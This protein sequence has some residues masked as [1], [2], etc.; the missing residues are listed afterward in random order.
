M[1]YFLM[2]KNHGTLS[3]I[4]GEW[5]V[6][7]L[8]SIKVFHQVVAVGSFTKAALQ[9]D[10]SVAMTSKHM[11][12]LERLLGTK[13]LHR[14]SRNIHLTEAGEQYYN[15]SLYALEILSCAEQTAKGATSIAQ[16]V[17]K[18]TMPSWFANP[19]VATWLAQFQ[20]HYP[21]V[22]LDLSLSNHMVDLV[23]NGFDLALRLSN[24]PK[25]SL[26]TR[27][28]GAVEFYPVATPDYLSEHGTPTTPESFNQHCAIQPTYVKMD[29]CTVYHRK[30][31]KPSIL[32]PKA[33]MYSDDTI[34][35][36]QLI[37]A[38]AGVGYM[39]SWV[40]EEELHSGRL[41]RLLPEYHLLSVNLYAAYVD[42]AFLS[43]KV[44][45]FIDFWVE[46]VAP[47]I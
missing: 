39:P 28:L 4:Y 14:N 21:K 42:R 44:R 5:F 7:T 13:L 17:L 45:A 6:D 41:V 12:H 34:M 16:G 31:N 36:A 2:G 35:T 47:K 38:G 11:A 1:Y 15:Q 40:V 33:V 25:P 10:M 9:L 18:I 24:E 46:Y 43:A 20:K 22:V 19:K 23:A 30:T 27:P 32:S 3:F 26:I 37:R 8:T 29:N